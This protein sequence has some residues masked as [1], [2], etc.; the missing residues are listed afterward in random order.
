[1]D[2]VRIG[3][4]GMGNME[5]FH[6]NDLLDGKVAIVTGASGVL[7]GA[8]ARALA[9]EGAKVALA[10]RSG[11]AVAKESLDTIEAAANRHQQAHAPPPATAAAAKAAAKAKAAAYA[12]AAKAKGKGGKG[13]KG[14]GKGGKGPD[15]RGGWDLTGRVPNRTLS[16]AVNMINMRPAPCTP[17]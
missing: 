6:A 8:C 2:K 1:M 16:S 5:R 9:R 3:I 7:G 10:Y 11:E 15:A 4:I 14:A 12:A 17:M 13:G